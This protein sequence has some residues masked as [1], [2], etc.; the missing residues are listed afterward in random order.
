MYRAIIIDD[1]Q[2]AVSL[3][4]SLINTNLTHEIEIV[5]Q[6]NSV[7]Q[8]IKEIT[9]H[10]PELLFLDIQLGDGTGFEILDKVNDDELKVIFTTA[11]NQY[12]VK[13]FD[14]H[15]IH[16][17][18]KPISLSSLNKAVSKIQ[19]EPNADKL[20]EK[21]NRYSVIRLLRMENF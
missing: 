3:L 11:F 19:E 6:A 2:D 12:A 21:F 9:T 1:E 16:Y 5:G 15:T 14:Y 20:L 13:A 4:E 17:L 18:L 7:A 10:Q 8:A